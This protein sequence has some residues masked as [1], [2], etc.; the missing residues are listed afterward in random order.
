MY[1]YIHVCTL[2]ISDFY[3]MDFK[4]CVLCEIC[5]PQ[6]YEVMKRSLMPGKLLLH[7]KILFLFYDIIIIITCFMSLRTVI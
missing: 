5:I 6:Y 1:V 7:A 3:I 4:D 2:Y